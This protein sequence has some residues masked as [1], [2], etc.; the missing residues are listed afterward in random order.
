MWSI[1]LKIILEQNLNH[2]YFIRHV[3]AIVGSNN[4]VATIFVLI[5]FSLPELLILSIYFHP[6]SYLYWYLA[7]NIVWFVS[8]R[9]MCR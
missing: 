5:D 3:V 1:S 2:C 4:T 7:Y 9:W 6:E 8:N